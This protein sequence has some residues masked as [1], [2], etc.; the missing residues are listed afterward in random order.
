MVFHYIPEIAGSFKQIKFLAQAISTLALGSLTYTCISVGAHGWDHLSTIIGIIVFIISTTAFILV[1]ITS[2]SPLLPRGIFRSR[3]FTA[4]TIVGAII[5]FGYYGQLFVL[6]LYFQ[7]IKGYSALE[8]GFAF[9]PQAIVSALTAFVCGKVTAKTGPGIPMT[10]GLLTGFFGFIALSFVNQNSSYLMSIIPMVVVGFSMSFI[11][12]ATVSAA[13]SSASAS[14]GGVVSGIINAARQ[15][16]SVL[17]IAILGSLIS[18]T[19]THGMS[20]AF[21]IAA[22]CYLVGFF[23]TV[24]FI[25][26]VNKAV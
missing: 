2:A 16:G 17:G 8:T 25:Y 3:R 13:M 9:L 4:A 20:F 24:S 11:A 12:P 26:H 21:F 18:H 22:A 19:F 5:N 14:D 7:Q 15:S 10:I 1:E 23:L 6:S